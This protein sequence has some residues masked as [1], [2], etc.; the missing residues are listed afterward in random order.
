MIAIA[1]QMLPIVFSMMV[2]PLIL[3]S[4]NYIIII[5]MV[6]L[7]EVQLLIQNPLAKKGKYKL[8]T[9]R[10]FK[11]TK[12]IRKHLPTMEKII[13]FLIQAYLIRLIIPLLPIMRESYTA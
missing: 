6:I 3:F 12:P 11:K 2:L 4:N 8:I 1:L 10:L 5:P 13:P 9:I 7:L